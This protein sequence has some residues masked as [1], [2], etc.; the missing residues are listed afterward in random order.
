MKHILLK[1][2]QAYAML[3][4]HPF[5]LKKPGIRRVDLTKIHVA[6]KYFKNHS[7]FSILTVIQNS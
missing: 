2:N 7:A 6:K 3:P 5:S 1:H 4:E